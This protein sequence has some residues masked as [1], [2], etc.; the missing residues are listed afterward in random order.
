MLE[1][2]SWD[3]HWREL[4]DNL[5]PRR[6]RFFEK[7]VNKG[8]KKND[9]IINNTGTR[10]LNVLV[11]GLSSGVTSPARKWFGLTPP[12]PEMREFGPVK[13]WLELV[14]RAMYDVFRAS[15]LYQVLPTSYEEVGAF[16]TAIITQQ[17]DFRTV[18]RFGSFTIGEYCL[19]QDAEGK[20]RT[21]YRDVP[22]TVKQ[23]VDKFGNK[24]ASPSTRWNNFSPEV[25]NLY[26][27][28]DYDVWLPT[29]HCLT[30][31]DNFVPGSQL[32]REF[33]YEQ[34]IYEANRQNGTPLHVGGF[35]RFPAHALRWH[36]SP[37]EVYGRSPGMDALG[38]IKQLQDMERKGG[39]ALSKHVNPPMV[40]STAMK[41]ERLS[42]LPGDVTFADGTGAQEGFRPAY[43]T[44]PQL[45]QFEKKLE[46]VE[47]R[48]R[49]A[50]YSDLFLSITERP[51]VQPLNESEIFERK[52]EK[53]LGLG[54]VMERLD[55]DLLEPIIDGTF[56]DIVE[57]GM[58]PEPPEEL[59][60]ANL[61]IEYLNI[62]AL[63][64]RSQGLLGLQD[65]ASFVGNLA[66]AQASSNQEV[67]AWDKFDIDQSIDE[68]GERRGVPAGVI[69]SDEDVQAMRDE[70]R[71]AAEAQRNAAL[72]QQAAQA[73]QSLGNVE[74]TE[75]NLA[76]D[77]IAGAGQ[78]PGAVNVQ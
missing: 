78:G 37:T 8:S 25:K 4:S 13:E 20:V 16:G 2:S 27:R 45:G 56:T 52:E 11:S 51:G 35:K 39:L 29:V 38:D 34:F 14:E 60:G 47:Q 64:Q 54:P 40:A 19:A 77:L 21:I 75:R 10:A 55:D 71:A 17:R 36:V 68:Y 65:T 7:D 15:N 18:N 9:R 26:D 23:M 31:N 70:R 24:Q 63:A 12:D 6:G 57:S 61:K 53:F 62:I 49:G 33:Q 73:A 74:T 1:R 41:S 28:G 66:A 67:T 5:L 30:E 69:R 44:Q 43:Q 50:F 32:A 22:M 58:V 76:S 46:A 48:I 72:A 59:S 3:G 42:T